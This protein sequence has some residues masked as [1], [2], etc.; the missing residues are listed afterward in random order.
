MK[1]I[2]CAIGVRRFQNTRRARYVWVEIGG[3]SVEFLGSLGVV[4]DWNG[5]LYHRFYSDRA[6]GHEAL[7]F[8]TALIIP[9]AMRP[10][11]AQAQCGISAPSAKSRG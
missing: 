8:L 5:S 3:R 10:A 9:K 7:A 1:A 6:S 4:L 11:A 2:R